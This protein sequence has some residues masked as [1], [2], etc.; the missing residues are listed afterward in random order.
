MWYVRRLMSDVVY[1]MSDLTCGMSGVQY[2]M[3]YISR[4]MSDVVCQTSDV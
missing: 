2:L 1:Q 4:L 3:W